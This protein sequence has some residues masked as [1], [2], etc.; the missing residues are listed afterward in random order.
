MKPGRGNVHAIG[1]NAHWADDPLAILIRLHGV[2]VIRIHVYCLH[3]SGYDECP[4]AVDDTSLNGC[5]IDLSKSFL[6]RRTERRNAIRKHV[7]FILLRIPPL[8]HAMSREL[9]SL[10]FDTK[11]TMNE[12]EPQVK[13]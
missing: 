1:S 12:S 7:R 8:W 13:T 3:L 9:V 10:P 11:R 4:W 2:D 5:C 6:H